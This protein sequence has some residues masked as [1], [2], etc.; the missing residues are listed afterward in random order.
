VELYTFREN[1]DMTGKLILCFF[2]VFVTCPLFGQD[3][4][5]REIETS[6]TVEQTRAH[7]GFLASDEMRGRDIGS[8]ELDIAANYI[9]NHFQ[10]INIPPLQGTI[11][12]F[13]PVKLNSYDLPQ[14]ASASIGKESFL[15]NEN[16][17]VLNGGSIEWTGDYVYVGYG[18]DAELAKA[19]IKGRMVLALAGSKDADD[20]NKM[21]RESRAK[22]RS[23]K[24]A[25]G[26]GL[27]EL[28]VSQ[29]PWKGLQ[30]FFNKKKWTLNEGTPDAPFVWVRPGDLKKLSLRSKR[31]ISGS[32]SVSV[33]SP[34]TINVKNVAAVLEGSDPMLKNE[35]IVITSHY[36]H[37]GVDRN[38]KG[39][40]IF[41][42]ARD[43][44]TGTGAMLQAAK[45]LAAHPPKRSVIFMAVTAEEKGSL[46]SQ[47]FVNNPLVTLDKIVLNFNSDGLGYNDTSIVTSISLGRTNM[48]YLLERAAKAFGFGLQ[49]DPDESEGFYER[50]DQ[51]SFA[52]AGIPAIKLQPGFIRMDDDI[53]RYY[54]KAPDHME[55]MDLDYITRFYRVFAYSVFLISNDS[56]KPAWN[57]GDKFEE[58]YRNL[59]AQ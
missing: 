45:F 32:L 56:T 36:D 18:S 5:V 57:K 35:Y 33:K 52:R 1:A 44:A 23:V 19:N 59:H 39:D 53:L 12:Y 48:D 11:N 28:V 4:I 51:I 7:I 3:E 8:P 41:N 24:K 42:G 25:G 46:G 49:G 58:A 17:I 20:I 43:N 30:N 21:Y 14:N 13:Q 26:I 40:S 29:F 55:S 31:K 6:L 2:V 9:R 34:R 37:I 38:Q 22:Y 47:W 10:S 27:V 15:L 16:L 54:H 50:S